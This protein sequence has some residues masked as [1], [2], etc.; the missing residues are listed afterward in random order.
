MNI[1]CFDDKSIPDFLDM[2]LKI[3]ILNGERNI[4]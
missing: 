4:S 3:F 2:H 1:L